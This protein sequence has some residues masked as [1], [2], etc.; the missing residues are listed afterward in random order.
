[1]NITSI[2]LALGLLTGNV[3]ADPTGVEKSGQTS[4]I[5]LEALASGHLTELQGRYKLRALM[6]MQPF[7]SIPLISLTNRLANA[8]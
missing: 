6:T 1:M 5:K 3:L 4:V 8:V 2:S 7:K